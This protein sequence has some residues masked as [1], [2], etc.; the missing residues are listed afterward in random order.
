MNNKL[1][2]LLNALGAMSEITRAEYE[3]LVAAG[4]TS[5]QALYLTGVFLS[6]NLRQ[7]NQGGASND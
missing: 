2:E 6:E 7:N 1:E 4:F 3:S 5:E